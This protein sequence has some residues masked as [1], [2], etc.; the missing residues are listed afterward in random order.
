VAA[1]LAALVFVVVPQVAGASLR[2]LLTNDDGYD[3]PG[4]RALRDALVAAGHEV[5]TVAPAHNQSGKG[6]SMNTHA[7]DYTPGKGL[8]K[9]V[10][11]TPG[12]ANPVWSLDG[13]PLDSLKAGL[14]VVMA[15]APPD[16]VV[17]G[18][19]FGQNLGI[20]GSTSSGTMGAALGAL[21]RG[22]P[23]MAGSVGIVFEERDA[24][25]RSTT[26]AFP[27]AAA[28]MVK[29]VERFESAGGLPRGVRMLNVNFPVPWSALKGVRRSRLARRGGVGLELFDPSRG[30]PALHV[31]PA[32]FPD[33]ASSDACF[34]VVGFLPGAAPEPGT[35]VALHDEG[36]I[37]VTPMD[38]D[39]TTAGFWSGWRLGR[40]LRGL[41]P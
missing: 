9:L 33:C 28:F 19:N 36:Y 3:A 11:T 31:P 12:D 40:F 30:L 35:D 18:L 32:P 17:S 39:M 13:T 20:D 21:V 5:V 10:D 26:E 14:S 7:F 38:G 34:V 8:M 37:T 1:C 27:L 16:L 41:E 25:F 15:G 24:H 2:I 22:I 29:L 23:S 6:G 4:L